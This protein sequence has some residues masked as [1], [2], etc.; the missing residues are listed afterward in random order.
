MV[1]LVKMF[2][3]EAALIEDAFRGA[4]HSRLARATVWRLRMTADVKS[5]EAGPD[6]EH[7]LE[8][9]KEIGANIRATDEISFKLLEFVPLSSG[10]GAGALVLL[11]KLTWTGA[12][13]GPIVVAGLS[14]IGVVV[15]I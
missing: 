3:G 9:Y 10:V 13:T 14:V 6:P 7:L 12:C 2:A 8:M 4:A 5:E 15:T 1:Q 11:E